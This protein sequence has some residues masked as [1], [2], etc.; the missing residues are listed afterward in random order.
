MDKWDSRFIDIAKEVS[1]WSKDPSTQ[2]GC[3]I[4]NKDKQIVS[5]GYN[6]FPK[7]VSDAPDLYLDRPT[8][9]LK[10][11]H[12]EVNAVLQSRENLEGSTVYVTHKPCSNCM[13]V[14]IQSGVGRVVTYQPEEG[15]AER[16]KDSFEQSEK[17]AEEVGLV[18]DYI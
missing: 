3:V 18:I 11:L 1:S 14:L 12:A 10:V 9:Y 17:M 4:V 5:T 2:V 13:S 8:K 15:L 7:G 16:F 6:G